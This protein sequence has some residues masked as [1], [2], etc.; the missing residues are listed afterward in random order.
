MAGTPDLTRV[1]G[2]VC[3]YWTAWSDLPENLRDSVAGNGTCQAT[4]YFPQSK[5]TC[6]NNGECNG[7]G[8]CR[9]CAVYDVAGLQFSHKQTTHVYSATYLL[10]WNTELNKYV[11]VR[12]LNQDEVSDGSA[13]TDT[14]TWQQKTTTLNISGEQTPLNLA[15]Y[16]LRP[17]FQKCCN[18]SGSP[19][20]YVKNRSGTL[21]ARS[22]TSSTIREFPY[23]TKD[24]EGNYT[25][26]TAL[27]ASC[28]VDSASPWKVPFT[29]EN[30]TAYGCN[31][32]KPECPYYTGPK[33]SYCV[34]S[35][36]Q[37]GDK[38]GA[39]Q[40]LELRF[41][42][43]NWTQ[44]SY[45]EQE[46]SKK[47]KDPVIYAWT[48]TFEFGGATTNDTQDN[49]MVQKVYISDFSGPSPVI[50]IG[51]KEPA[52]KGLRI[53]SDVVETTVNYP[54]LIKELDGVSARLSIVWPK[55][56]KSSNP[57]I[58]RTF[59]IGQ[60]IIRVFV[61]TP[62]TATIYAV[63]LTK[64][65]QGSMS[66]SDFITYMIRNYPQ[67]LHSVTSSSTGTQVISFDVELEYKPTLNVIKV[68]TRDPTSSEGSYLTDIC[69]VEHKLYHAE[70]AQTLGSDEAGHAELQ[71]W[72]DRFER[73]YCE[74]EVL[75]ISNAPSVHSV[76]WD[77][78]AGGRLSMY[79]IEKMY[80][81]QLME[82]WV[83][84]SCS[85]AFVTFDNLECSA[86]MPWS[87]FG[88]SPR[89]VTLNMYVDRSSNPAA[90]SD[91]VVPL[92]LV[93]QSFT[94]SVLPGNI[95][96]TAPDLYY[97]DEN[98]QVICTDTKGNRTVGC[99]DS[100]GNLT[101]EAL[102]TGAK[103]LTR[104][105]S[106]GFDEKTDKIYATYY[107]TEYKQAPVV[108]EDKVRLKYP[109]A[110]NYYM[111]ELPL[112][113]DY[114]DSEFSMRGSS[115]CL[116]RV[117][118]STVE[119]K[120]ITDL[121]DIKER[122]YNELLE[123][124]TKSIE[125]FQQGGVGDSNIRSSSEIF[126]A[127]KEEFE[128]TYSEY[129][130]CSDSQ[131]V[132]LLEVC[133]RLGELKFHEGD[134][135]FL[136]IFKDEEGRPIGNKRVSMLLQAAK[137]ETRDVEIRYRWEMKLLAWRIVDT[138][139]LLAKYNEPMV[140]D[141]DFQGTEHYNPKCG[142][143][144]EE[145]LRTH[146]FGESGPMWYP[147]ISCLKPKYHE[148]DWNM[149]VKCKNYVEGFSGNNN[150]GSL[151]GKRWSYWERMRGND[152]LSTHIAGTIFLVGCYYRE[153]SYSYQLTDEQRFDGY[154]RIRSGHPHGPNAR[155]REALRV[156][157]HFI[158]RNLKVRNEVIA[159]QFSPLE[160]YWT[161]EYKQLIFTDPSNPDAGIIVG[162]EQ[163][164]P[165]WVHLSD[166]ISIVNRTTPERQHP[167]GH[168][169]LK[170]VGS[171]EFNENFDTSSDNRYKLSSVLQDR[172]LTSTQ[173]R[174]PDGTLIYSPGEPYYTDG[175][176]NYNDII[177]VYKE[178][179]TAWGWLER[180]KDIVR[181][182]DTIGGINL[183][184]PTVNV[185]KTDRESATY[186]DEGY[187]R[188]QYTP[189][190]FDTTTGYIVDFPS[191]S[192]AGG[193]ER[194]FDWYT[195]KWIEDI[196]SSVDTIYNKLLNATGYSFFGRGD[197]GKYFLMDDSGVHTYVDNI[198]NSGT[199]FRKTVRCVGVDSEIQTD[200]LPYDLTDLVDYDSS[201][202]LEASKLN[203]LLSS[204]SSRS[205]NVNLSGH[206]YI[207]SVDI[208]W[209]FGPGVTLDA[210][211]NSINVRYDIPKMNMFAFTLS[212]TGVPITS[213]LVSSTNYI[214]STNQE[215][216]EVEGE[217]GIIYTYKGEGYKKV[218][219]PFSI[220]AGA[221]RIDFDSFRKDARGYIEKI[222][223]WFRKPK[224]KTEI[225]YNYE[226]KVNIST[227]D[228][229][230]PDYRE[231]L[232]YYSRTIV[233]Y[234]DGL[235]YNL[236]SN[237]VLPGVSSPNLK[238]AKFTNRS[239]KDAILEYEYFDPTNT[240][241]P[242]NS[243]T[244]PQNSPEAASDEDG[245][246]SVP[247]PLS[248]CTKGRTLYANSHVNDCPELV[249][250]DGRTERN[251]KSFSTNETS[252]CAADN[253]GPYRLGE[254]T[255]RCLYE[256]AT[257]LLDGDVITKYNWFWH[258]DE[259]SF[260]EGTMGLVLPGKSLVLTLSS[261]VPEFYRMYQ[262]EHF[263]CESDLSTTY[264][265]GHLHEIPPW[266][267]LGHRLYA[268]NPKFNRAC[269]DIV[270]FKIEDHIGERTYGTAEYGGYAASGGTIWPYET[271]RDRDHYLQA[272]L[273]E[274]GGYMGGAI[275]G[276]G[277]A[278]WAAQAQLSHGFT[279][280]QQ[281]A[282]R[283]TNEQVYG[284][285]EQASRAD[286]S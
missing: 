114:S 131:S 50:T 78:D 43:D 62:Y 282:Q 5:I 264:S 92:K 132:T 106:G 163:E 204:Y 260:W 22:Y 257:G 183:Y 36:M 1:A 127:I 120:R 200:L 81:N 116:K 175:S 111:T 141:S 222:S 102:S 18:W 284:G 53:I 240:R 174:R 161:D 254:K 130:F 124:E 233:E 85:L 84:A 283:E 250:V 205:F 186:T 137:P 221:V 212:S 230:T 34:D 61:D 48:G 220:F 38:I 21:L 253:V 247:G 79:P 109:Y 112:E 129:V 273:V 71:P 202:Y 134:Y 198:T 255:Q 23:L 19:F 125:S 162:D 14:L 261:V 168:Y 182:D 82:N 139:F 31:G 148:D 70:V 228:T 8:T 99:V 209:K 95:I 20:E 155:D 6:F 225:L 229:G 281:E 30:S 110:L 267:A 258:P 75:R 24:D 2:N 262:H 145:F 213:S 266:R 100:N 98:G 231:M 153:V 215:L 166:G 259:I 16:N 47:F 118:G 136:F 226:Q 169:L 271:Y 96:I 15:I 45:P 63:N 207:E 133:N 73:V 56:T 128:E 58:F 3:I 9:N 216:Q 171:H 268:G 210:A 54:T 156:S 44:Y 208:T 76:L 142:D 244:H 196:S 211:G 193:A 217:D 251:K 10:E 104:S 286:A 159:D 194:K 176:Q 69:Y 224:Q 42:S 201:I 178:E 25:V 167:F 83:S 59:R 108:P 239:V 113:M 101:A 265:D 149:A 89:G 274:V 52:D 157:R 191:F 41:Y 67:D 147:Y 243:K 119:Y 256:E 88:T 187:N 87:A 97:Y 65:S 66:D 192:W 237:N 199:S 154:T 107:T 144:A 40:I 272:G 64:Y 263:G 151:E 184:N 203:D 94:G 252:P 234:G 26:A 173:A 185:W 152:M 138:L 121:T 140:P 90:S 170:T 245:Y 206:Y 275:G 227:G 165:I 143:H 86:I 270:I 276:A 277:P 57:F 74:A 33:W 160:L 248:I 279:M 123:E 172:D 35:K 7:S 242:Y 179:S 158:K 37:M 93:L 146:T 197:G 27:S 39:K 249:S 238:S 135:T 91:G 280:P 68:F 180:P 51:A 236:L 190:S 195:G 13:F 177:P 72:I 181:G 103:P 164:T 77:S 60:N 117:S 278:F 219:Y 4:H 285:R 49:P 105:W 115:I 28:Q 188:L 223:I 269:Y 189:P 150:T 122:L 214:I 46:Y 235:S 55:N 241:F 126:E 12:Q 218:N 29:T 17:R 80:Y 232:Y 32:C 246:W 11:S